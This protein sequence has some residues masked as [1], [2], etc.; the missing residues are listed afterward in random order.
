[1]IPLDIFG[2]NGGVG[3][4]L[5]NTAT[6][7]ADGIDSIDSNLALI[8]V[9]NTDAGTVTAVTIASGGTGYT[10]APTVTFSG[11]GGSGATG[12]ANLGAAP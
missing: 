9:L 7:Q 6:V 10:S 5:P 8:T 1:M 12:I 2:P 4:D 3:L 11:G